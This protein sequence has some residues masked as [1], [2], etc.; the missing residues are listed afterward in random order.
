MAVVTDGMPV[1]VGMVGAM[2]VAVVVGAVVFGAQ[3]STPIR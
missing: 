1:V 3:R 2:I